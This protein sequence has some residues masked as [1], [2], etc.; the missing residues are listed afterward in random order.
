MH[1]LSETG[2]VSCVG[3]TLDWD[4]PKDLERGSHWLPIR[5]RGLRPP[6]SPHQII[7]PPFG[8]YD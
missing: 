5:A 1:E 6:Q 4:S 7:G 8:H 2:V 3:N